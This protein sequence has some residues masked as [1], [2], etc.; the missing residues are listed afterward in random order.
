MLADAI[1]QC[2]TMVTGALELGLT[3]GGGNEIP[4]SDKCVHFNCVS[5]DVQSAFAL[6]YL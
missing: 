4:P 2:M 1:T 6:T 5:S 3:E